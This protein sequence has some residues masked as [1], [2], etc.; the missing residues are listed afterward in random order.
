MIPALVV[1]TNDL[2]PYYYVEVLDAS[3]TAI[4]LSGATIVCTMRNVHD[5]SGT[6][7]INRQSTGIS[8]TDAS[9]GKFR[10]AWQAGETDTAGKYYI[11]FEITPSSGGKFTVPSD[12]SAIVVVH[13]SLDGS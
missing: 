3:G 7:K 10:Y 5:P 6:P 9:A 1:K 12:N 11:E 13:A 4:A 2:Q 8:I